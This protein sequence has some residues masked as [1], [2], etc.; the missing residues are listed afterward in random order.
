[1]SLHIRKKQKFSTK[2]FVSS[3]CIL[4]FVAILIGIAIQYIPA[5]SQ[6]NENTLNTEEQK[7]NNNTQEKPG[8]E[9]ESETAPED[10]SPDISF[11]N[12]LGSER[13]G[14]FEMDENTNVQDLSSLTDGKEYYIAINPSFCYGI[15]EEQ[16]EIDYIPE[17]QEGLTL[18]SEQSKTFDTYSATQYIYKGKE[19]HLMVIVF[20]Y[21]NENDVIFSASNLIIMEFAEFQKETKDF[22]NNY[23]PRKGNYE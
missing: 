13:L 1:M 7:E 11:E 8:T 4:L 3:L 2:V 16:T 9:I 22:I 23:T 19:T 21:Q 5:N 10:N 18:I 15:T 14:F 12:P 6:E 20:K 17:K